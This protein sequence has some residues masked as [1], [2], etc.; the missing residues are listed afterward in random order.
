MKDYFC[1]SN[2]MEGTPEW[3]YVAFILS[4]DR[5]PVG[6]GRQVIRA[7]EIVENWFVLYVGDG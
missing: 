7:R 1:S 6:G 2:R 5:V 3:M 4:Q